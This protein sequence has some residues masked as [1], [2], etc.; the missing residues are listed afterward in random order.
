MMHFQTLEPGGRNKAFRKLRL[1]IGYV[2]F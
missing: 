1:P 2:I